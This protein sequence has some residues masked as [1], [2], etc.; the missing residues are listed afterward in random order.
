MLFASCPGAFCS[1]FVLWTTQT[2]ELLRAKAHRI[3]AF[4]PV[5]G[6]AVTCR[7]PIRSGLFAHGRCKRQLL[8]K[9][10]IDA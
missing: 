8:V 7:Q 3:V 1:T 2:F 6:L 4:F 5:F 9:R 10:P